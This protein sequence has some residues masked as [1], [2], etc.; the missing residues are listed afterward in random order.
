MRTLGI[1][2]IFTLVY[3]MYRHHL[4]DRI[5]SLREV[6]CVHETSLPY[7]FFLFKCLG[8]RICLYINFMVA[9]RNFCDV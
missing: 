9:V 6:T 3:V 8:Y 1:T 2:T 7:H 5:I 4:Y